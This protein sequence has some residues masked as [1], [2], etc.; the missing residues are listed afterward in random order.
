MGVGVGTRR[1]VSC[2]GS[3]DVP[4]LL[5]DLEPSGFGSRAYIL[6]SPSELWLDSAAMSSVGALMCG[7]LLVHLRSSEPSNE[8]EREFSSLLQ[9]RNESIVL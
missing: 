6:S 1:I 5:G 2:I 9:L 8:S 3:G 7:G 4:R